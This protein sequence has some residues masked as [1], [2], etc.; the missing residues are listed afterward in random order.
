M[1]YQFFSSVFFANNKSMKQAIGVAFAA[2]TLLFTGSTSASAQSTQFLYGITNDGKIYEVDI[3][4]KTTTLAFTTNL[5]LM[6]GLAF[7]ESGNAGTGQLFYRAGTGSNGSTGLYVWNRNNNTQSLITVPT[8]IA[9]S[10]LLPGQSSNA[11]WYNGAYWYVQQ[12]T[13]TLTKV[14]VDFTNISAPVVSSLQSFTNFDGTSKTNFSFGDIS[15][16]SSGILYG[17]TSDTFFHV[18]L[19]SGSPTSYSSQ[20]SSAQLQIGFGADGT[21]LYG[22]AAG[23]GAWYQID[24]STGVSTSLGFTSAAAFNDI[25]EGSVR[26]AS[27]VTAPEPSSLAFLFTVPLLGIGMMR[28]RRAVN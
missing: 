16:S 12:G 21:T 1:V 3:Q 6:N 23:T 5:N 19:N 9:T 2:A 28:R 14:T 17:S 24:K 18:D 27:S 10:G 11:S 15:I 8:S 13:D 22:E 4:N 25:S 26:S 7:N 20:A